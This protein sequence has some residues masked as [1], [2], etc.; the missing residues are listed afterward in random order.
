M[1]LRNDIV[2]ANVNQRHGRRGQVHVATGGSTRGTTVCWG[3]YGLRMKDAHRRLSA[4][5]LKNGEDTIKRRL[6]GMNYRLYIRV[7]CSTPVFKKGNEVSSYILLSIQD[8]VKTFGN[9]W[10]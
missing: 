8:V 3:D 10:P 5:Q 4:N 1:A 7:S 6:R 9:V 2:P